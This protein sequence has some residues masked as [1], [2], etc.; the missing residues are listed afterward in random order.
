VIVTLERNE[1]VGPRLIEDCRP[2]TLPLAR[3]AGFHAAAEA[4]STKPNQ[5]T[6]SKKLNVGTPFVALKE[7]CCLARLKEDA[8]PCT[9]PNSTA[10]HGC[11]GEL[12][13]S[14]AI[15]T[16]RLALRRAIHVT[17]QPCFVF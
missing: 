8:M 4:F 3:L 13:S 10:G 6:N 17:R 16:E 12:R 7:R 2:S 5:F 15:A 1:V 9:T 11:V 14:E